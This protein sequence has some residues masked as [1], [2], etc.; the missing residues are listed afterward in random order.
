[1][2]QPTSRQLVS[3][4][5]ALLGAGIAT[6]LLAACGSSGSTTGTAPV[7]I[8]PTPTPIAS[9][10][11]G[12]PAPVA[13]TSLY[14]SN[15]GANSIMVLPASGTGT[16]APIA[17]ISGS[18]TQL[19]QPIALALDAAGN[20][21]TV[22]FTTTQPSIL[23]FA[24][25][26]SGNVAP[27]NAISSSA[28][29]QPSAIAFDASGNIYVADYGN[30]AI[31]VFAAGSS[32]SV[33]PLRTIKGSTTTLMHPRGLQVDSA[34]NIWVANTDAPAI[35]VFAATASGNAAPIRTIAGSST[36]LVKPN[37]VA[38]DAAGNIYVSNLT[39]PATGT[40]NIYAASAVANAAPIGQYTDANYVGNP[41][42]IALDN[43][44][45]VYVGDEGP[46]GA[47]KVYPPGTSGNV[48]YVERFTGIFNTP[49]GIAVR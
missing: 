24:P 1:M 30:D 39:P 5:A 11:P 28:L 2:N 29:V 35:D 21:W 8:G 32:G 17:T 33:T 23:E 7:P 13:A 45:Y 31:D 18:Q 44:G 26:A 43:S 16:V 22:N 14:V 49:E 46:N 6:L 10:P 9:Y 36:L 19:N 4:A 42:G 37:G 27:I 38:L 34:G 41:Y 3:R 20:I 40:V 15:E 48:T 47:V 12:A 25:T